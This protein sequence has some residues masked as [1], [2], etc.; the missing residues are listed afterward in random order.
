[1][2][3]FFVI[4][5]ILGN[6]ESFVNTSTVRSKS[7]SSSEDH[8]RSPNPLFKRTAFFKGRSQMGVSLDIPNLYHV[9]ITAMQFSPYFARRFL[10]LL[11][12][13]GVS[14]DVEGFWK[15]LLIGTWPHVLASGGQRNKTTRRSSTVESSLS[16][17]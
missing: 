12:F 15:A 13:H 4:E 16:V 11:E 10:Y 14:S 9:M 1:M 5:V 17:L 2:C 6:G 8:S 3:G 7:S